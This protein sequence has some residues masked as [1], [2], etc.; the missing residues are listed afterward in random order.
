MIFPRNLAT[1]HRIILVVIKIPNDSSSIITESVSAIT[2]PN[3]FPMGSADTDALSII[4]DK[5]SHTPRFWYT[6]T[7]TLC[8]YRKCDE[9]G[10]LI[11]YESLRIKQDLA[12]IHTSEQEFYFLNTLAHTLPL[13]RNKKRSIN[14]L[15][16]I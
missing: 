2:N 8:E 13:N 15:L 11:Y 6:T 7:S 1:K 14:A 12:E 9:A 3:Q 4:E 10:K 16:I 5:K